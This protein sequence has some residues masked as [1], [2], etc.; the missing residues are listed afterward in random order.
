MP[1]GGTSFPLF[2][3]SHSLHRGRHK[4]IVWLDREGDCSVPSKTPGKPAPGDMEELY[5]LEK[6]AKW[7][8]FIC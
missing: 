4:L 5:R 2:G 7:Y 8:E 1:I 6:A 3:G